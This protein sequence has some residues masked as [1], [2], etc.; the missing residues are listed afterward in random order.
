VTAK[1]RLPE[2]VFGL[3]SAVA[4][5]NLD[6]RPDFFVPHSNRLFLSTREG[7]YREAVELRETFAWKPLDGEDWPCGACFADLNRDGRLD[8][9]LAIHHGPARNRVYLNDGLHNGV[10]KFRDV[11]AEVGLGDPVP[12]RCPH[13]EV[14]DFDNDGW[15]DI[16][17]S[18]AWLEDGKVTPLVYRNTGV[19]DGLPRF[20]A[21]RPVKTANAY[22]PAGPSADYDGDGRVDLFLV[23]W[24]AGN[25]SRLLRNTS[26]ERSWLTV[27]VAGRTMNR[28]GVGA[29]IAVYSA[30]SMG[31]AE[32]LLGYQ[33][34]G[35]GF[36]YASG[37]MPVAHFGLGDAATV[38]VRVT[39][40]NGVTLDRPNQRAK[41]VLVVNE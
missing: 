24:F 12:V 38:D 4:D 9:V 40:P 28:M 5:L 6:G 22:F 14:Q 35:I 19:R 3:G 31:K 23:N 16:Y 32:G 17:L 41:Q 1:V 25:H 34:I 13:V 21:P 15:P 37:Q 7:T 30:G 36:G 18:A 20:V 10:P 2:N 39:L 8:L 33:E 26:A 29:K 11:T 27:R